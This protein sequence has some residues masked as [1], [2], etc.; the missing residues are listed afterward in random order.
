MRSENT[1]HLVAGGSTDEVSH[2][3]GEGRTQFLSVVST[4]RLPREK[5]YA[6]VDVVGRCARGREATDDEVGDAS[7]VDQAV[8]QVGGEDLRFGVHDL[9]SDYFVPARQREPGAFEIDPREE[10]LAGRRTDVD[11]D[12]EQLDSL[13][14]ERLDG[15]VHPMV[16]IVAMIGF[17]VRLDLTLA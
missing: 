15:R 5:H 6:G 17:G 9:A 10:H 8:R 16:V 3:R 2:S 1:L 11:A 14:W 7:G 4:G 12:A 13:T